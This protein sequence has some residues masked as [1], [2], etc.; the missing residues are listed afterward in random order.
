[1]NFS[2]VMSVYVKD[3]ADYLQQAL[4]SLINQTLLPSEIIIVSDGPLTEN[5]YEVIDNFIEHH[6]NSLHI[7][8]PVNKGPANAWN[9][10]VAES[11]YDWIARMD[12]D[13]ICLP[14][15]FEKQ[16]AYLT[17][18]PQVALLGGAISEFDTDPDMVKNNRNVP[19]SLREI[20]SLSKKR[21]PFNHVTVMFN[22]QAYLAAGKYIQITGFVDYYLWVRML[23]DEIIAHNLDSVL[24][25]VRVGND[26]V[27]RRIGINYAKSEFEFNFE[28]YKIGFFSFREAFRNILLRCS[29]RLLPRKFVSW[30]YS[31]R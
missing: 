5:L 17:D 12:A 11:G 19:T 23:N 7:K 8:C 6:E 16:I 9:L 15:R 10:G 28:T 20:V 18:N 14:D 30:M 2:V 26:M 25:K 13:D 1:M 24:V 27:G 29:F 31:L 22:K 3:V 4:D 21:N